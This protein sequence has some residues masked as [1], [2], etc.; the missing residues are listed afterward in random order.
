MTTMASPRNA[1]LTLADIAD[2]RAYER[3]RDEFRTRII[4]LKARRRVHIGTIISLVFENR[5]TIRFQVQE[6][7]RVEKLATDEQIQTELDIYNA[8][9]PERGH[10]SATLFIECTT[11]AQMREWFPKL[12]GI[13]RSIELRIGEGPDAV[14]VRSTPEADHEAQL[15]REE[16]TAA[17]HYVRFAVGAEHAEALRRGPATLSVAHPAYLEATAL[18]DLTRDEL[19]DDLEG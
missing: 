4:E 13:E 5:E 17:V 8:L 6:M 16:M 15:T 14:V 3:E 12:V 7:A 2:V 18:R 19:A 10:L 9:I 1:K 11:D